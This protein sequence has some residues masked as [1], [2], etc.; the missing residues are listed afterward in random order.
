MRRSRRGGFT[1]IELM[2]VVAILGILAALA[3]PAFSG[4]VRRSK[5]SEATGNI[6]SMFVAAAAYYLDERTDRGTEAQTTAAC[7]VGTDAT[8]VEPSS[9]KR[10]YE[11]TPN[12]RALGFSISDFVY[13]SYQVESAGSQCGWIAETR[14]L[15]FLRAWG[16]L[17][18][19]GVN[20]LY[21][22]GVGSDESNVLYHGRGIY[23]EREGE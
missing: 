10:K 12:Q 15:Y 3:I 13:F 5:G 22:L 23:V 16:D 20:S 8:I 1:L 11:T 2:I 19:D 18:D 7:T 4:Y 17:D 14:D 21:E 6:K 9:V